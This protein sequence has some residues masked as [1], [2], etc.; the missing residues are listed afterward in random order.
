MTRFVVVHCAKD[1]RDAQVEQTENYSHCALLH[2]HAQTV[3]R[4]ESFV[5]LQLDRGNDDFFLVIA[6]QFEAEFF[7]D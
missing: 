2:G 5:N 4:G 3:P 7:A 1:Y 6:R